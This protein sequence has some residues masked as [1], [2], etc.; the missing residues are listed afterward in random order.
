[1]FV[2]II[3]LRFFLCVCVGGGSLQ[4]WIFFLNIVVSRVFFM[5]IA[6]VKAMV[7]QEILE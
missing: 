5:Y 6:R 1:M 2:W 4:I 3:V 7:R